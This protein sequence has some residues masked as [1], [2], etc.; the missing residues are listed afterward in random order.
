MR[1][2]EL[3]L[4]DERLAHNIPHTVAEMHTENVARGGKMGF[5]KCLGGEHLTYLY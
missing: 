1:G 5:S 4:T 2:S 3:L